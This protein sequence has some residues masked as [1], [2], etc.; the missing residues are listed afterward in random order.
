MSKVR[1]GVEQVLSLLRERVQARLRNDIPGKRSAQRILENSGRQ[2]TREIS[3]APGLQGHSRIDQVVR[4]ASARGF[5]G[6]EEERPVLSVVEMRK[7]YGPT[8]C[9]SRQI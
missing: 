9:T 7:A 6:K 1:K 3:R 8:D 5:V 2:Q 4:L